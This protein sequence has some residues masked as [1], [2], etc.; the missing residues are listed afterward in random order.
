MKIFNCTVVLVSV[1]T[2]S[3]STFGISFEQPTP[4]D[5]D[6]AEKQLIEAAECSLKVDPDDTDTNHLI[7]VNGGELEFYSNPNK[8]YSVFGLKSRKITMY[9]DVRNRKPDKYITYVN[10][11]MNTVRRE[12]N[13]YEPKKTNVGVI[14]IR[15]SDSPGVVEIVC[16]INK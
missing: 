12:A 3:Q 7:S 10:A 6:K 8:P 16:T 1:L 11:S 2:M 13:L 14:D 9:H 15:Y 4:T 5:I